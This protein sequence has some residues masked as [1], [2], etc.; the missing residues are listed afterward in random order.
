MIQGIVT[1]VP[2]RVVGNGSFLT[3]DANKI[4]KLT[5]IYERRWV[6]YGDRILDIQYETSRQVI[7]QCAI[8]PKD[9]DAIIVV[10]QTPSY[11]MPHTSAILSHMLGTTNDCLCLD[12]NLG[13]SGYLHALFYAGRI[14]DE[15]GKVLIVAGDCLSTTIARED[16]ATAPIFGDAIS[17]TIYID[18]ESECESL[19]NI[20]TFGEYWRSITQQGYG[21]MN[22]DG[23]AVFNFIQKK[24]VS[25]IEETLASYDLSTNEIDYFIF[26]QA[27]KSVLDLLEAKLG[28]KASQVPRS[29]HKFG[30]TS[31]ASIPLTLCSE[32][33]VN[34]LSNARG[35][36]LVGFGS[37]ASFGAAVIDPRSIKVLKLIE[38]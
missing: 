25:S 7:D 21:S 2:K 36:C 18:D 26:H 33:S 34:A 23:G 6:D 27:N 3:F 28:L 12:I 1:A 13:C 10:T 31:S 24:V 35:I 38:I 16:S 19:Y 14:A 17:A 4:A 5:G 15:D 32:L 37:G 30:N 9:L 20:K 29:Y 22:M 8:S 11:Q